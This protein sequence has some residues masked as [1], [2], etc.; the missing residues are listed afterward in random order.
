MERQRL[1]RFVAAIAQIATIVVGVVHR[2]L[3]LIA[4]RDLHLGLHPFDARFV[5]VE[6]AEDRHAL[7]VDGFPA[8]KVR[9]ARRFAGAGGAQNIDH[10]VDIILEGGDAAF[11][12]FKPALFPAVVE[13]ELEAFAGF[14]FQIR[15]TDDAARAAAGVGG[16]V[17][18]K[19][20]QRRGFKRRR[21]AAFD[22]DGIGGVI[23]QIGARAPVIAIGL[24]VVHTNAGGQR[25]R[26]DDAPFVFNKQGVL[27]GRGRLAAAAQV[28]RIFQ[29]VVAPF[30]AEGHQLVNH[31]Q[32]QN[33]LAVDGIA[34][35]SDGPVL[36][37][38]FVI[39]LFAVELEL[40]VAHIPAAV[41]AQGV[42]LTLKAV[43]VKG[44]G[45]AILAVKAIARG[46]IVVVV[47]RPGEF[48]I[49]IAAGEALD[50]R[51]LAGGIT[52]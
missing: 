12:I 48:N 37:R 11:D 45:V 35:R 42:V 41:M 31:V 22:G 51:R 19:L 8:D 21:P 4:K 46:E 34:F 23:H 24:M 9:V 7:A 15:V 18:V 5:D 49:A 13:T 29:L 6:I 3:P 43:A 27:A 26:L 10:V 1:Q 40:A 36:P 16:P 28:D 17:G 39:H 20:Q 52:G 25:Q 2:Q 33:V 50:A 47:R 32:R 38:I 44:I 30:A 14:R